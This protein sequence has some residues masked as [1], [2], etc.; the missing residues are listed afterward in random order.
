MPALIA[1]VVFTS[2]GAALLMTPDGLI[3]YGRS[4]VAALFSLSNFV[5]YFESG[6]WDTDA[7]LK[8][9]LHT[10]SLGVEE[11]FYLFWPALVMLLF[12]LRHRIPMAMAWLSIS[13]A[14]AALC[15]WYTIID[16]DA[17]F[18][19]LPFRVFQF[20]FG[21]LVI[22]LAPMLFG[23]AGTQRLWARRIRFLNADIG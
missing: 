5:F 10:W 2:A 6:Y 22:S 3:S 15:A 16:R 17:A 18:Y 11:Q 8:P 23:A 20:S 21:A 4:A 14:G 1:T 9:L 7:E 19:L 13:V 12:S